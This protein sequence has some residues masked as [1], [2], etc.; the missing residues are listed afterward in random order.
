MDAAGRPYRCLAL[1]GLLLWL[2][3]AP[4]VVLAQQ[5]DSTARPAPRADLPADLALE[6]SVAGDALT[7]ELPARTPFLGLSGLLTQQ[8]GSFTY[9]FG[10][11][12]WPEGWAP[13]AVPPHLVRFALDGI[14][15][16]DPVTGR[17]RYELLPL[18]FAS[19]PHLASDA[20][21][22]GAMLSSQLRLFDRAQPLTLLRYLSGDGG[23]Q[24]VEG[25]HVQ[26]RRVRLFGNDHALQVA[27]GYVGTGAEG[28]HPR[29]TYGGT[30]LTRHR[31]VLAR[32]RL[33]RP[34]WWLE[35]MNLHSRRFV[36]AHGGVQPVGTDLETI[37]LETGV[38][39]VGGGAYRRTL[40]ND[41]SLTGRLRLGAGDAIG[42]LYWTRQLRRFVPEAADALAIRTSRLGGSLRLSAGAATFAEIAGHLDGS[43]ED[44][45][46]PPQRARI[47]AGTE[48]ARGGWSL[49]LRGDLQHGAAM[50]LL[51]GRASLAY[52]G[53]HLEMSLTGGRSGSPAPLAAVHGWTGAV[54]GLTEIES[55]STLWAELRGSLQAGAW[56][57]TGTFTPRRYANAIDYAQTDSLLAALQFEEPFTESLASLRLSWRE[58]SRRGLYAALSGNLRLWNGDAEDL[59]PRRESLPDRWVTLRAGARLSLFSGDLLLHGFLQGR[60]WSAFRSRTLDPATGLLVLP[61]DPLLTPEAS[62]TLDAYLEARV[63]SATIVF[64]YENALSGTELMRGTLNVPVYPLPAQRFRFGVYWPIDG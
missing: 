56:G 40:R 21:G 11:A 10:E 3:A 63:R 37:Y 27:G 60:A 62:G 53:P 33:R 24:H 26:R 5:T 18:T 48:I 49:D 58:A 39:L 8:A 64:A 51:T 17:P 44:A 61:G 35:L 23:L 42:Q 55:A 19:S 47:S 34:S 4:S 41:L 52:H 38:G 20:H 28:T 45:P 36:G 59:L 57:L 2:C 31:Q 14:P 25:L 46:D 29:S 16:D 7:S 30:Q 15:L 43:Y 22:S 12:G 9:R 6:R 32:V 50:P 13:G 1:A 54:A